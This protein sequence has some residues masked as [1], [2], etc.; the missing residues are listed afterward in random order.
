MKRSLRA[1]LMF[2]GPALRPRERMPSLLRFSHAG[3]NEALALPALNPDFLYAA[4]D[5]T[6]Y[7]AFVK[8][9]RKKR[10]GATKVHRK[11][12][13][14]ARSESEEKPQVPPLRCTPV[15]MTIQS[16]K[17]L[18]LPHKCGSHHQYM[19]KSD[20][21]PDPGHPTCRL[22]PGHASSRLFPIESVD[23]LGTQVFE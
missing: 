10:A 23:I 11:S 2:G 20:F 16:A 4:Q 6:A 21:Q 15:G 22:L 17:A 7:A 19:A 12:G 8:K 1:G 14:S 18:L 9:S 13:F 3:T 5:A